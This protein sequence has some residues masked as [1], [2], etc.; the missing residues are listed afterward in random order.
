MSADLSAEFTAFFAEFVGPDEARALARRFATALNANA[1]LA[2]LS[3]L[4]DRSRKVTVLAIEM[5]PALVDILHEPELLLW[6][7]LAISL[8]ERSGATA[9]KY[10]GESEAIL[11][12]LPSADRAAVLRTALELADQDGPLAL[13]GLRQAGGVSAMMGMEA[14]SIWARIGSDLARCDYV[15]GVEYFRRSAEALAVVSLDDLKAWASVSLK[16]VTT[17]SLGKPDYV[18]ALTYMRTS[19]VL[20]AELPTHAVRRRLVALANGLADRAPERAI[21]LLGEAPGLLLPISTPEWQERVLQ[22]GMLVADKDP[23]A[24]LAY[25][26]RAPEVIHLIG[27]DDAPPSPASERFE[28]WFKGGMEVL[29]Y[30]PEAARAYFATETR[31]ALEAVEQAASGVALRDVSRVLK[32]FAEG[33]S[34]KTLTIRSQGQED[35][36]ASSSQSPSEGVIVLPARVRQYATREDNLRLY[37][38]MTAH[39]AGH[40]E[41]GTY[42][43]DL[44]RLEDLSAQACLRYGRQAP[45]HLHSLDDLFQCYPQP[46]LIRD[47]WTLAEDARI[48]AC[49]KAEYPGLRRDM[50]DLLREELSKRSLT[51]GMSV[52]EMIVDLLLQLSVQPSDSVQVPFALEEVVS[53]AWALLRAAVDPGVSAEAVVRAVHRAYVLIEE[54]TAASQIP[55]SDEASQ[56]SDSPD[57]PRGGEAQGGRYRPLANFAYRGSV[58][59]ERVSGSLAAK[60]QSFEEPSLQ[61]RESDPRSIVETEK[62]QNSSRSL[63]A[64]PEPAAPS[65]PP[66]LS[67]PSEAPFPKEGPPIISPAQPAS[68]Q[69]DPSFPCGE[70]L[71]PLKDRRVFL[72]DEWDGVIQDYR[73]QWCRVVEQTGP[74]GSESFVEQTRSTYAGM[75]GMLRRYFEG[76][77][78][79]ALRRVRRQSDGEEVDI[80]AAIESLVERQ[81]QTAPSED[82]YIRRD[83]R[84]RD[85]AVAFLVD[86]SGSTGRH[87]GL[88]GKRIIDVEKEGLVL[89]AEALEAIG[90]QYA[91]YGYSGKSRREIQFLILKDFEERYGPAIWRRIDGLRPLVQNR[92]GA[93]IR[94]AVHRL[95]A[96]SARVKLLVLL[97]DGRPLDDLYADEYALEDT[98]AA[99]RE[100]KAEGVH[101][102]CITVDHEASGYLARMYG[103]VSYLIID[104]VESLPER[105]PRIYRMLTT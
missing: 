74:E 56:K 47:L 65:H 41:Y 104:R 27:G 98:K 88:E 94:H 76:I 90:D 6:I 57:A 25:V 32:L 50:E 46:S 79:A 8:T 3:E 99:L 2:L 80:E 29:D 75:I 73:N 69:D 71:L 23:D 16:L 44:G 96:R 38:L 58:E 49:L 51:Y 45:A 1:L 30:S 9:M 19:A 105:L 40:F 20:L 31:K 102:F 39:E 91:L 54:L 18:G 64:P 53:R 35:S 97:S 7:D 61:E 100:A 77:R 34:G 60:D 83:R 78:P 103:D 14:L 52:K 72:Y 59:A 101:V 93:A 67:L 66:A 13:E 10:C 87:L 63:I 42:D 15:I 89:L 11:R 92:D 95:L 17:N 36:E 62:T 33:L 85:V 22:Y 28:T 48:E 5:L 70:A 21:E 81:A 24:A 12:V 43:V 84:R 55:S 86:L 4:R 26:R 68:R 82:V 37:K